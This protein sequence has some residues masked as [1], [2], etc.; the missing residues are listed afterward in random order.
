MLVSNVSDRNYLDL[1]GSAGADKKPVEN[2]EKKYGIKYQTEDAGN[3]G[4]EDFLKLMITQLT[5]QDFT[6]P[7][8]D[9]EYMAQMTQFGTLQAMQEMTKYS[10]NNYAM[11]MIGKTVTASKYSNGNMIKET[12]VVEQITRKN[13]EYSLLING[14][15]FTL[16][17][18]SSVGTGDVLTEDSEEGNPEMQNFNTGNM[19][20]T[21]ETG[22]VNSPVTQG[23]VVDIHQYDPE[24]AMG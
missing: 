7:T 18:I 9:S 21:G 6:N 1:L 24:A 14:K 3:L 16:K 20:N 23:S 15:E 17:Q 22:T 5:N 8:N 11:S 19:I 2:L 12:G 10:Q 13:D 4:Y